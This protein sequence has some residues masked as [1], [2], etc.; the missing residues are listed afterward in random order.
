[1]GRE[2]M[3]AVDA[4]LV[5]A[6]LTDG[7]PTAPLDEF[8]RVYD[9]DDNWWW[10]IGCGHHQNLFDAALDELRLTEGDLTVAVHEAQT[11]RSEAERLQTRCEE[12]EYVTRQQADQNR[13]LRDEVE[14]LRE[15]SATNRETGGGWRDRA[16]TAETQQQAALNLCD[17][18][19]R[20]GKQLVWIGELRAAL[21]AAD[22]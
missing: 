14:R 17:E 18:G 8:C 5:D 6:M 3:V 19:E 22:E 11:A 16:L 20:L 4:P 13:Q 9:R 1:M 21:G 12:A 7:Q 2:R 15:E 10:A